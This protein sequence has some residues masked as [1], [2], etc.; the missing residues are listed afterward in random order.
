MKRK[1]ESPPGDHLWNDLELAPD[2]AVY[3][4]DVS[5]LSVVKITPDGQITTVVEGH[6]LRSPGG[7]ALSAD[8]KTLYVADWAYGLA[9]VDLATGGLA[10]LAPPPG[11]TVLGVD[12]LRRDGNALIGIQNGVAPARITRF[13]LAPDGRSIVSAKLLERGVP[14]WDEPTLGSHRRPR[15][16]LHLQQP[17]APLRR[18]RLRATRRRSGRAGDPP[19][20]PRRSA[21]PRVGADESRRGRGGR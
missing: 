5:T 21:R 2:G 13:E 16:L 6:G 19:P 10:W 14:G 18:R 1:V 4:S 12:G 8:G 20:A 11:A 9:T 7:L 3:V 17:L 15:P